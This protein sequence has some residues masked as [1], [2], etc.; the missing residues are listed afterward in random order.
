MLL[1]RRQAAEVAG[2]SPERI[3]TWERRGH[4]HRAGLDE[5]GNPVYE[6]V[7]VAKAEHR[8]RGYTR[9]QAAC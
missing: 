7:E 1:T 3:R 4:L 8:N 9:L 5:S 2:V 6:A